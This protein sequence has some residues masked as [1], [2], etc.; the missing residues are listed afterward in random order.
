M[1][2]KQNWL[3]NAINYH[4]TQKGMNTLIQQHFAN[5]IA[6]PSD[7]QILAVGNALANLNDNLHLESAEITTRST[8]LSND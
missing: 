8:I 2:T 1:Q 3:S 4:F 5:V 6:A 7:E